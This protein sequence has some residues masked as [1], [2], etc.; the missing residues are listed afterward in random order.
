M[1]RLIVIMSKK[2]FYI[3]IILLYSSTIISQ[4]TIEYQKE[5]LPQEHLFLHV[6]GNLFLTG[7]SL[8]YT[9]YCLDAKKNTPSLLS[10][11]A[12]VELI[13]SD[14][15]SISK[16]KINLKKGIGFSDLFL[17]S[18]IKTGTYKLIS[19]TQWMRNEQRF[20][21][22]NIYVVNPFAD[23]LEHVKTLDSINTKKAYTFKNTQ[24]LKPKT[25][26][27]TYSKREKIKLFFNTENIENISI[28]V[29]KTNE[30]ELPTTPKTSFLEANSI[31]NNKISKTFY[32]PEF[33]GELI[34]GKI[35]SSNNLEVGNKNIAISFGGENSLT[36]IVTTNKNGIFY[37]S[38]DKPYS[39]NEVVV[40]VLDNNQYTISLNEDKGL[41]ITFS[42]F[43]KLE[44]TEALRIY[45]KEQSKYIQIENAYNSVKQSSYSKENKNKPVFYDNSNTT[46]YVLDDF[47]RFKTIKEVA[48]EILKDVWIV[49][50]NN[51]QR[52]RLR[53]VDLVSEKNLETLLIVDGF[54]I[55]NHSDFISFDALK[56]KTIKVIQEKYFFGNKLYQ[57]IIDIKTFDKNYQNKSKKSQKFSL[58]KP[59]QE[60]NYY[61]P[62]YE[63]L[64][65]KNI[66]DFRTQLLWLP[67]INKS[68]KEIFFYSSDIVGKFKVEIQGY[69]KSGQPIFEEHFFTV[70]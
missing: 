45:I 8:Y 53:D 31:K 7:E 38:I 46:T 37:F 58:L 16:Q 4:N 42:N 1:D 12:Y 17:S 33:R 25:D 5:K 54:I 13:N 68:T 24:F 67:K 69:T 50:E 41:H 23:K 43:D 11:I 62:N 48:V 34:Q 28:S 47:K 10:K 49:N 70:K 57:G 3:C 22:E 63:V 35:S 14:Q 15:K 44:L 36:K 18:S 32:I 29:K 27:N 30:I 26:K 2:I 51:E 20:F 66:P 59:E 6:N 55:N 61:H 39:A 9:I 19:Y 65:N 60:K 56:I 40:E 64:K 21:E 52:F